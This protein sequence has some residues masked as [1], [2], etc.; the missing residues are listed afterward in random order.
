MPNA[1]DRLLDEQTVRRIR[2]EQFANSLA[3]RLDRLLQQLAD[4]VAARL[5][6]VN[7]DDDTL[8]RLNGV[9]ASVNALQA[10]TYDQIERL[11]TGEL[12]TF[13]AD[14]IQAQASLLARAINTGL[15]FSL[16][17]YAPSP[18]QV[19]SAATAR[20]MQGRLLRD[21]Y[22]GISRQAQQ[23]V[24]DAVR[25]G[26]VSGDTNADIVRRVIGTRAQ[27]NRDG[28]MA[29]N[30]RQAE[31]V[32]RTAVAHYAAEARNST[33]D[34]NAHLAKEI[35]WVSTLDGRTTVEHCIPR[36]LARYTLDRKP[37]GHTLPWGAGPGALH[38][39]C[40]ST[41]VPRITEG[42]LL[43]GEAGEQP[44]VAFRP[45]EIDG[46]PV[47]LPKPASQMSVREYTA[48]LR[49]AG[50]DTAEIREIESRFIGR[51]P[52]TTSYPAFLRRQPASFQ[53]EVLGKT[54]GALFRRGDLPVEKFVNDK[55]RFL[56]LDELRAREP[57]AF[58]KA[59]L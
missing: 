17:V 5:S 13:A 57:G 10:A 53:D 18:A 24:S 16:A 47:T 8:T 1:N 29:I 42:A 11:A 44:F 52:G 39:N 6:A 41:S 43:E 54:R 27:Q 15:P 33:I 7:I 23:R 22:R 30:R 50:L 46:Q 2:V 14:E 20:P 45:V 56:T 51:L 40:R 48:A 32:T 38:F 25:F 12:A 26:F 34:A 36:H 9:L 31:T 3:N 28:A 55:G 35:L 4:D 59:N 21:W 37:I 58:A 19:I 49:R